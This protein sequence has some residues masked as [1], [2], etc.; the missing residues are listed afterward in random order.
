M[1]YTCNIICTLHH[2]LLPLCMHVDRDVDMWIIVVYMVASLNIEV[3][4]QFLGDSRVETGSGQLGRILSGSNGSDPVYEISG[5]NPDSAL[6]H[7][8]L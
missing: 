6:Y 7:M 5:A 4:P 3:K 1:H 8:H 2:L